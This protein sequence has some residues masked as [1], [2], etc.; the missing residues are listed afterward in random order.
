MYACDEIGGMHFSIEKQM[1][2]YIWARRRCLLYVVL[3]RLGLEPLPRV[4]HATPK[5]FCASAFGII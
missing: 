2:L 4:V 5:D 3:H 1:V